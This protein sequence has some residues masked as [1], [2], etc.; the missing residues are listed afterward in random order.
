MNK[1]IRGFLREEDGITALEYSILAA[2]VAA[3]LVAAFSTP[4]QDLFKDLMAKIRDAADTP[5][6]G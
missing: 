3:A 5:A 2:L 1:S 6:S 4:L